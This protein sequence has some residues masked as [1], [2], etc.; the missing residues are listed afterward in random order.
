MG[1]I[2]SS[3]AEEISS[4][5]DSGLHEGIRWKESFLGYDLEA[6][7]TFVMVLWSRD[8]PMIISSYRGR[9]LAKT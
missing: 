3:L 2:G 8:P 7:S 1:G 9:F 4:W 6:L 5:L